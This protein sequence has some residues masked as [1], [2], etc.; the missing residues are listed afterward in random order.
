M[1]PFQNKN[2][3]P[4][5]TEPQ[6]KV[7]RIRSLTSD[8]L[9]Q[10]INNSRTYSDSIVGISNERLSSMA[11]AYG[12]WNINQVLRQTLPSLRSACR[13]LA[14]QNPFA[15]RYV[16][17][18]SNLVVGADG[19]TVRPRP[20][21]HDCTTNQELS[22]RLEKAFYDWS[23]NASEFS[24][25]GSLSIDLFQQLVERTRA[26]DGECFIRIHRDRQSVKFSIIDSARIPSTKN[27]ILQNGNY[28]SNGIEYDQDSRVIAYYVADIH[29]LNYSLHVSSCKRISADEIIHY[30]IPEFPNQQRG[31]PDLCPSLK[32]L[33][34]YNAYIEATL[35]GKR[36]SSS[37]MAFIKNDSDSGLLDEDEEQR[38][39]FE[40][41]EPGSIKELGRGQSIETIN[42][43]AGV[44]KISEFSEIIM[45]KIVAGLGT[46]KQ[47]LTGDTSN[48][49]FSAAK[50]S[51]RIQRDGMK[52][53]SNLMIS[54]V[55]KTIY[56][57]WLKV[58]MINTMKNLSFSDFDNIKNAEYILP[59]Q[60]SLD[61]VKD[62][63]YEQI[64][65]D[66]GVKSKSQIIRDLNTDPIKV[67][68]EINS[69]KEQMQ[70]K[71]NKE[72]NIIVQGSTTDGIKQED[73]NEGDK[74]IE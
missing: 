35:I 47:N 25:D 15:K 26:I 18:S 22:E 2:N 9:K 50:M 6:P 73:S 42:P 54:K 69:E 24:F 7:K 46:T 53:R 33:Q 14:V 8:R 12:N 40:Y 57:E 4:P 68:E 39:Y 64:L 37:A 21:T 3:T 71:I 59:K 19:I 23:E 29:P 38:E 52:T 62:A 67:F 43:T 55:L 44:D 11:G 48:A 63:Q 1:W 32:A 20:L 34:D 31:I 56:Q 30:F 74:P 17:L 45:Q 13:H 36:I 41:L 65:L 10:E 51:D 66:M 70:E 60:I 61:P 16:S 27:E 72:E 5:Q 58:Y 49:S 28:I